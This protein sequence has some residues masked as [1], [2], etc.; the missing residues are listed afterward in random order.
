MS[1]S[2]YHLISMGEMPRQTGSYIYALDHDEIAWTQEE[3]WLLL[4]ADHVGTLSVG[5]R[6]QVFQPW[7]CFVVPPGNRCRLQK[8]S[9]ELSCAI[10]IRFQ[11][12]KSGAPML[13]LPSYTQL[14]EFGPLWNLR[15]RTALNRA[16][17]LQRETR[18]VMA[19]LLWSIGVD[20]GQVRVNAA[21]EQAEKIVEEGIGGPLRVEEL[22]SAVSVSHN[23]LI[24]LFQEEHGVS[25][26]EYIRLRRQHR[27]CRLILETQMPLKEVAAAVGITDLGQFSRLVKDAS[28]LSPRELRATTRPANLFR[29]V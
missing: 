21:L 11:P 9:E 15:F 22:A 6:T 12:E 14:G 27:A 18:V 5:P 20:P 3:S 19:D 24:R 29:M 1:G 17:Q 7:A 23:Q 26:Q 13:A 2:R 25:P 8:A 4:V 28:G 10:W 16:Y